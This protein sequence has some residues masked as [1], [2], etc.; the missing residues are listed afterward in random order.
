MC[1]SIHENPSLHSASRRSACRGLAVGAL[2]GGLAPALR[3]E[4]LP[5]DASRSNHFPFG[6]VVPTRRIARYPVRTHFDTRSTL[7]ELL[8]GRITAL[9]L[10]FTG[11][12]ATCPIQG[13]LFAQAQ[14]ELKSAP[15]SAQFMSISID[16]LSDTPASLAAWLRKFDARPGWLAVSPRIEDVDAIVALLGSGGEKRRPAV[17]QDPHT[18]QVYLIDQRGELV[19]RLASMPSPT[20]IN[21]AIMAIASKYELPLR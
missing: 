7:P 21:N 15:A 20:S 13:A 2:F 14:K 6:P 17:D 10:M 1:N 9:Q 19:L 3:A 5:I 18:G 4:T 16:P 8:L 12:S 11:C